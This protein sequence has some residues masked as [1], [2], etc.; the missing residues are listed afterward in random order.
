MYGYALAA[1]TV[2]AEFM[3]SLSGMRTSISN[4]GTWLDREW[5]DNPSNC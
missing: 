3:A 1:L 5:K 4:A 2:Q